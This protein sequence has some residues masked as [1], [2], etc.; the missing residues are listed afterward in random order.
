LTYL[1]TG[2][3]SGI[4]EV[5]ALRLAG[6][7][8][9]VIAGVTVVG[10]V[11]HLPLDRLREQLEVNVV[12][13]VAVTQAFLPALRAG[14]GRIVMMSSA[15]GR[16]TVP[17][18]GAYSASKHAVEAVAA[19]LRQELSPWGVPVVVIEPGTFR[20]RNRAST[21]TA[22]RADRARMGA[23]AESRY[24]RALDALL[25]SST[26]TEA[27]AGDP[28]RV[29]AVVERALTARRP[30]T[31]Y[32]VGARMLVTTAQ[33]LPARTMDALLYRAMGIPRPGPVTRAG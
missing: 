31:R 24:G 22:A 29:A 3:S 9:E 26:R 27:A 14:N 21:A 12:G 10:P 11:E 23:A 16:V 25:A 17:L 18:H 32:L 30:R 19:A 1:V 2:A 13:L 7:G 15:A 33:L 8:H 4:G 20:S 6:R 5:T 28:E